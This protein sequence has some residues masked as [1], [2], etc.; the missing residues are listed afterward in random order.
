VD[1]R[2]FMLQVIPRIFLALL[3]VALL[4]AAAGPVCAQA[5]S[6]GDKAPGRVETPLGTFEVKPEVREGLE[7][8][9]GGIE[10]SKERLSAAVRDAARELSLLLEEKTALTPEERRRLEELSR[11]LKEALR[12]LR[13]SPGTPGTPEEPET[14][15]I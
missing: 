12:G 9:L 11:E 2:P 8:L 6:P 10:A 15:N 13:Q 1:R 3:T 5:D 4:A 14:I 7:R